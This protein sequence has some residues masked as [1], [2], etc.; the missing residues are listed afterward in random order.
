MSQV[1][2]LTAA[3]DQLALVVFGND[4]V[5]QPRAGWFTAEELVAAERVSGDLDLVAL[6]ITTPA[7][8]A[9][10]TSLPRGRFDTHRRLQVPLL[11]PELLQVLRLLILRDL[12]KPAATPPP[13]TPHLAS[14]ALP[15]S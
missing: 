12:S 4:Q 14:P 13:L 2:E 7:D 10:A 9:F 15:P 11:P 1:A 6:R 5:N 8:Q 3:M